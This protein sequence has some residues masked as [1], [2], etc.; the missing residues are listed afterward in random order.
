MN[1][2]QLQDLSNL[3]KREAKSLFDNG[4]YQGAYYLMGYSVECA[5]KACV[6]KQTNRYDFPDKEPTRQVYTHSLE[7]LVALAGLKAKLAACIFWRR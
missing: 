2:Q 3:R 4:L 1:R 7:K 5:L 6:A